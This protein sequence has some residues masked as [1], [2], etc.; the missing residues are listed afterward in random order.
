MLWW[1]FFS[2]L[3]W[4]FLALQFHWFRCNNSNLRNSNTTDR[5][6]SCPCPLSLSP[7]LS[8]RLVLTIWL[9][10]VAL[11]V[12]VGY[13]LIKSVFFLKDKIFLYNDFGLSE[14]TKRKYKYSYTTI[15]SVFVKLYNCK[16]NNGKG[17]RRKTVGLKK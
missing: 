11:R 12:T 3:L 16:S 4:K 2:R 9:L 14:L 6:K 8:S 10:R 13:E 5:Y 17:G 7:S 1:S 15:S